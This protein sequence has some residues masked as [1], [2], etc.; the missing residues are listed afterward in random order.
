[1]YFQDLIT[2]LVGKNGVG[3]TN[4]LEALSTLP[5][6]NKSQAT[7]DNTVQSE[8]ARKYFDYFREQQKDSN[9]TIYLTL[10][11]EEEEAE[12]KF[13]LKDLTFEITFD[14]SFNLLTNK[15]ND[16]WPI[17]WECNL[18]IFDKCINYF[19]ENSKKYSLDK[20][21]QQIFEYFIK[22]AIHNEDSSIK[23]IEN[24]FKSE[25]KKLKNDYL[26]Q[27][28][29]V[30]LL[31]KHQKKKYYENLQ[32]LLKVAKI[33]FN[34]FVYDFSAKIKVF[35]VNKTE[36]LFPENVSIFYKHVG[37]LP[38][39]ASV[40]PKV[41]FDELINLN[42]KIRSSS[43]GGQKF[44]N[45]DWV[46]ALK[47][48]DEIIQN[49]QQNL[50]TKF[51]EVWD[52]PCSSIF[53]QMNPNSENLLHFWFEENFK[54][55]K[56]LI[57][58]KQ[59]SAGKRMFFFIW[60]L[61]FHFQATSETQT[62]VIN[63]LLI[64]ELDLH[65]HEDAQIKMLKM[66][67]RYNKK[68][69]KILFSTHS[70]VLPSIERP[71]QIFLVARNNEGTK[72]DSYSN[73]KGS[74]GFQIEELTKIIGGSMANSIY[75]W[76]YKNNLIVEGRSDYFYLYALINLLKNKF[77]K[78]QQEILNKLR[79]VYLQGA[80]QVFLYL[81]LLKSWKFKFA[82]LLDSDAA[83]K[84][85]TQQILKDIKNFDKTKFIFTAIAENDENEFAEL[86]DNE[87]LKKIDKK[88]QIEDLFS[89]KDKN[90]YPDL[91]NEFKDNKIYQKINE[92]LENGELI[93]SIQTKINFE[94]LLKKI[95]KRFKNYSKL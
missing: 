65:L 29:V 34:N 25:F 46:K 56:R 38:Y 89:K 86:P 49:L 93:L 30:A 35:F 40:A 42:A 44:K 37:W 7:I 82:V 66:F 71:N 53:V 51:Q 90:K 60:I 18:D 79:I 27:I 83:G 74:Q 5:M 33:H 31:R 50:L 12:K 77:S 57:S 64:D 88:Q 67:E 54:D 2:I 84:T 41:N 9:F 3:K 55:E 58:M 61:S 10:I 87:F 14:L 15:N 28:L 59:L 36:A 95:I 47:E 63:L 45:L 26:N 20:E 62:D 24:N 22:Q 52:D 11:I 6:L 43:T 92:K 39:L 23:N 21:K 72:I 17:K 76:D 80:S 68:T 91:S 70:T 8:G 94:N 48:R 73:M 16:E 78:E 75:N 13:G 4:I 69:W 32:T 85:A 1:M 19:E 81:K